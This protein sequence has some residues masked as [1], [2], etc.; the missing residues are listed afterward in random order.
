[1]CGIPNEINDIILLYYRQAVLL[2]LNETNKAIMS[3]YRQ[4]KLLLR[5]GNT[6][7][8]KF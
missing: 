6:V 8:G 5:N 2:S 7:H 3:Y 1:M 4:T